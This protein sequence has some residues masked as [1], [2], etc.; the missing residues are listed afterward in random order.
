MLSDIVFRIRSLFRRNAMESEL[1]DELRF[2]FEHQVA[3][4]VAAGLTREEAERRA[5]LS[6]G[7]LAQVKDECREARGVNFVETLFQDVRYSLRTL[8]KTPGFTAIAILTLALGIGANT[9]IFSMVD[10]LLLR[11][12]PVKDPG[13]LTYVVV[14]RTDGGWANGFSYPNFEDIRRETGSVFSHVVGLQPFQMDGLNVDGS[15]STI[16]T[17]YVTGNFFEMLG[18][19]PALGRF[20]L[21]SE[22]RVAGADPVL[23]L[24]YSFWQTRF[25]GDPGV[26]GRKAAING[27][28]VTIIGV[29]PKGFRGVLAILDTQGY[30]P[31]GMSIANLEKKDSL[32]DR[33]TLMELM[34]IARLKQGVSLAQA[35][36]ALDVVAKQLAHEYPKVDEWRSMRA[37]ALGAA[38]PSAS[39]ESPVK[40]IGAVFLALAGMVLLL[41]CVNVA[42]LLLV[43]AGVRGREMAVRS[44]L[45][46]AR[47][48]LVRQLLTD[49]SLLALLGCA[50][51]IVLGL[52][53]SGALNAIPLGSTIPVV[54][55]FGLNW[56]VFAYA[57]GAAAATGII[58]GIVPALR[59]SRLNLADV[60]QEGGRSFTAGRQRL[61]SILVVAEVSGSLTLLIVAGLF[62]RSLQ[63]VQHVDLG[64]DPSHILNVTVD[65]H[66]AGYDTQR[67]ARFF[68]E[69]VTRV[70]QMP[71]VQ[72]A[73][74]AATVPM[75]NVSLGGSLTINGYQ[76]RI[77]GATP[78]AGYNAVSSGY[79]ATMRLPLLRGRDFRDSDN[80][81]AQHVA[82]INE[83]MASQY[84]P[85]RDP[86]GSS[87]ILRED[88]SHAMQIVGIAK[89]SR[90]GSIAESF[91]PYFY[92][93]FA[94]KYTQPATL[95][96]R[97]MSGD[98]LPMAK[99]VLGMVRAI[100]PAMPVY[101][102]QTMNQALE[103]LNGLLL[104]KLGAGL[105]GGLGLLGLVLAIVG[106]YGV[107][108]FSANQRTHEIGIRMALGARRPVILGMIFRQGL[109]ITGLG[110]VIGLVLAAAL[111]QGLASMLTGVTPLDPLTYVSASMLLGLVALVACFIPARR[112]TRVDPL[113]SL[114]YE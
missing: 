91:A 50:G 102:V 69:L 70:R 84:W 56:R 11:P 94:Q 67:S 99:S 86:I 44:A 97:V 16:W 37:S 41:A 8:R 18:I 114:R 57:M 1:D 24:S 82:V 93:P 65:P 104:Y 96:L 95:Q 54:L 55:E 22:G 103:S 38:P 34:I 9:A 66:E 81:S 87:F 73:T 58:V 43:R 107:V 105:A 28:P 78:S 71:G 108:S 10:W 61:R 30:L 46:A 32:A 60:L 13:Q 15:T 27:H 64:F 68:D 42:A 25:G 62:V 48:R 90:S 31:M 17:S 59:A 20:I 77:P 101:D 14:Q 79:F 98:P 6:F 88:P 40:F 111:S 26:V 52:A 49:S 76:S 110:V 21:P 29:A 74:V 92:V 85:D 100:E 83:A 72:S 112:A 36:P 23:V 109:V 89:N 35:Q 45:G 47:G 5:R 63:M 4:G 113:I 7:G 19:Q 75:G 2:H 106:V 39:P 53:G 80:E 3:K 33:G 12:L 51:G